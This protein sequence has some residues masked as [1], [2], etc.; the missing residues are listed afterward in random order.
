MRNRIKTLVDLL[1]LFEKRGGEEVFVYRTGVRR[2]TFS[3]SDIYDLSLRMAEYLS[4]EGIKKGDRVALYAPNSPSWAIAYFGIILCGA[5]VV[6]I[7]FASGKKRAET[8]VKLSGSKLIIQSSYK[9]EKFN[10][11]IH[12]TSSGLK[13]AI[14]EDLLFILKAY[15]PIKKIHQPKDSDIAVIVYT[16]GTTGDPKGVVLSHENI[17]SNVVGACVH[18]SLPSHFN[19]LSVLPL[20]H[21]FEQTVGFL[22]PLYRG[23]KIIYLR[24][25]KPQ[26]IMEAFKKENISAMLVVPRLLSLFKNTIEQDLSSKRISGLLHNKITRKIVA[27]L[28]RKKFGKN[29]Q[30]F[31]SGG[32]ALPREV[33]VFWKELGFRVV[34]GYGLTE[35]SPIV[36][37]NT[38]GEQILG[39]VG[40]SLPDVKTKIVNGEIL[41]K[42]KS[43][44]SSYYQNTKATKEAFENGWFKTGDFGYKDRVGNLFI[45]GRKKDVIVNASGV[46]I[47][48][49]EIEAV[50]NK[51]DGVK[52]SCV[53]GLDKGEGEQVYAVL[54]LKNKSADINEII[55]SANEKLDPLQQV[56]GFSVWSEFDFPRTTTLKI[57]KFKVK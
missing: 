17:I 1:N 37:G 13:T 9:F 29:F 57:Q 50:I 8:I 15:N 16:S 24:I 36:C 35:C 41:V 43:I 39:S 7:D 27:S 32:A 55:K 28:V 30:M 19:F 25:V 23:D 48:P 31:A 10:S 33:F 26:A 40:K 18:V 5:I 42:G 22:T 51:L 46:N 2:F 14:I 38:Y 4:K 52:D 21:M 3:Y 54:L 6:P 11:S 49:D 12:S 47:Y 20:S 53:I 45:K 44:F 34:E 56:E